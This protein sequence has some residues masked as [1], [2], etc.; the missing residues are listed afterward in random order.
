MKKQRIKVAA[1]R[2]IIMLLVWALVFSTEL[3]AVFALDVLAGET[4]E[5]DSVQTDE[6]EREASAQKEP[7]VADADSGQRASDYEEQVTD[8]YASGG[9]RLDE[10]EDGVIDADTRIEDRNAGIREAMDIV[11]TVNEPTVDETYIVTTDEG[12]S[13]G[14]Y[15]SL[16]EAVEACP[17]ETA[18]TITVTQDDEIDAMVKIPEDKK[19]TL[20]SSTTERSWT[21]RQTATTTGSNSYSARHFYVQGSLTLDNIVLMGTGDTVSGTY[22]GGVYVVGAAELKMMDKAVITQCS[23][24]RGGV[25]VT[26]SGSTFEMAGGEIS[27]NTSSGNG[28]GVYVY[29]GT[30][31]MAG[32]KISGNESGSDGGGAYV[33]GGGTLKLTGGEISGNTSSRNGGGVHVYYKS[34]FEMTGGEISGNESGDGGGGVYVYSNMFKLKGGK[35]SGNEARYGGGVYVR[36]NECMLEMKGGKIS[37]NEARYGGG[38]YVTDNSTFK[39]AKGE[40]SRNETDSSGGGAINGGGGVYV[41][42]GMLEMAGG[43]ISGNEAGYYGGGVYVTDSS[44]FKMAKGEIGRNEARYGGGVCAR[45]NESTFEMTEGLI[46]GNIA[47]NGGGIYTNDYSYTNPASTSAYANLTI[48]VRAQ[49]TGNTASARY[50]IPE[51]Y[52][53]FENFPGKLLNNDEINYKGYYLI[54]YESNYSP[55]RYIQK[56]SSGTGY[57]QVIVLGQDEVNFSR[58]GYRIVSWNTKPDGSG[59][60]Y[61]EGQRIEIEDSLTLYALWEKVSTNSY[62]ITEEYRRADDNSQIQDYT[63]AAVLAGAAYENTAP[64][65]PGY[66][67][68]GYRIDDGELQTGVTVTI[69]AVDKNY[70]IT[71]VYEEHAET[72]HVSV[73]VKLLWAAYE[74]DSGNVISPEY[75]FFNHSTY[76]ISVTLQELII[77]EADDL[78][79]VTSTS[80]GSDAAEVALQLDPMTDRGGWKITNQISLMAGSNGELLGKIGAGDRGFFDIIGTYGGDFADFDLAAGDYLQPEY[81][82]IFKIELTH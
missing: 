44:T 73:P 66:R 64:V 15:N 4:A 5:T 19:I 71:Y 36:G 65:L 48:S 45:G 9:I 46:T 30:L 10:N 53:E 54:T 77:I 60:T 29:Q 8:N 38:V 12:E 2:V 18:C 17:E 72:I 80:V 34:T 24:Y 27:G 51:N 31:E 20:T 52:A 32:G 23:N 69:P 78:G 81:E 26:G 25:F 21:I 61:Q 74:S 57:E 41:D 59:D 47:E 75:Y 40:I 70:R 55:E 3:S 7:E 42:G 67:Y 11:V 39:M 14:A 33:Y 37:G 50:V 28:G 16:E 58:S 62:N 49:V 22:N 13:K 63:E 82:A 76:D 79:L 1:E 68:L 56:A 43:K 35:I 6:G